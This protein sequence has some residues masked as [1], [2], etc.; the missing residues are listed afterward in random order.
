[1]WIDV[2]DYKRVVC[3]YLLDDGSVIWKNYSQVNYRENMFNHTAQIECPNPVTLRYSLGIIGITV[4]NQCPLNREY[5]TQPQRPIMTKPG[6]TLALCGKIIYGD[7]DINLLIEW[8]EYNKHMGVDKILFYTYNVTP[9]VS[10]VLKYYENIGLISLLPYKM[11][12]EGI[13]KHD[14]G[15]KTPEAWDNEQ[16]VVYDCQTRLRLYEFV[17]IIDIDEYI[18]PMTDKNFKIM[19]ERIES[20]IPNIAA[21]ETYGE[22]YVLEWKKTNPRDELLVKQYR[23]RTRTELPI[24]INQ[25]KLIHKPARVERGSVVTHGVKRLN[26]SYIILKDPLSTMV[27]NHYRKC[28]PHWDCSQQKQVRDNR[29]IRHI[30]PDL[31]KAISDA[32]KHCHNLIR[33]L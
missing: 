7:V 25:R 26:R 5:Y 21:V 20:R 3:C 27:I 24:D 14:V 17:G 31:V 11:P 22:L 23:L 32:K 29:I 13:E 2:E 33:T 10:K 4:S 1:M 9:S 15:A 18:V 19:L 30:K 8:V 28:F 12:Y 16:M 6:D